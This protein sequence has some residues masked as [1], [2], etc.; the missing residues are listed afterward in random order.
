MYR[1]TFIKRGSMGLVGMAGCI[2]WTCV[3]QKL[4]EHLQEG[5]LH[6]LDK[7][8][9]GLLASQIKDPTHTYFGGIPDTYQIYHPGSIGGFVQALTVGLVNAQSVFFRNPVLQQAMLDGMDFLWRRQHPD[10]TIDLLTTNFNSTPDTAFI[11]EPLTL[12][13]KLLVRDADQSHEALR[14]RIKSFLVRAGDALTTGGIHTPNH[15]WVVCMALARLNDLFPNPKYAERVDTWL[16]EG[17]DIDDDGQYTERSTAV[18]SPLTDRCLITIARLMNK[19]HLY[20]P[21]RKNLDMTLYFIHPN[22]EIVTEASRRQDQYQARYADAYYYPYWYM[23]VL[24][25]NGLYSAMKESIEQHAGWTRLTGILAYLMEDEMLNTK[26]S[27]GILPSRYE[28]VFG[29]SGLMR[30][31]QSGADLSLL[32]KNSTWFTLHNHNAVLQ[33]I[34]LSTAFFGKGQF[35]PEQLIKTNRGYQL[36]Q[37]MS[38]PYFQPFPK[39]S[40]PGDGNWEKMPR[41]KRPESE[42]QSLNYTVDVYFENESWNLA[43]NIEGTENVPVA[44]ELSFREG[45][46]WSGVKSLG[47]SQELFLLTGDIG[48][49]TYKGSGI[50]FGPGKNEHQWTQLRGAEPRIPGLSVYLTGYTPFRHTLQIK[51]I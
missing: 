50:Q 51:P 17:I 9:P 34:R 19:P 20:D 38:G 10:G 32:A 5:L 27:A 35:I 36:S 39:D 28:K 48:Q 4:P 26:I 24:D 23:A 22:G 29:A 45:G 14:N 15:R 8:I 11:V 6:E 30:W 44:V 41:N 13:Y 47:D 2:Q 3:N 42:V 21:V 1:R 7:Q 25:K 40:L 49:Y 16:S 37:S 46:K 18:Y 31:R 33:A 43:V 12:S